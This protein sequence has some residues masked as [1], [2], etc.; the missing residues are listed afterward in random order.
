MEIYFNNALS[1]LNSPK[2]FGIIME[3]AKM[4]EV[5]AK[6]KFSHPLIYQDKEAN[7]SP[8]CPV[9]SAEALRAMRMRKRA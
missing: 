7:Y 3:L 6:D 9:W 1:R 5:T 2:L 4:E 8:R